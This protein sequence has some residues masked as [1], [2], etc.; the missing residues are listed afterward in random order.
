VVDAFARGAGGHDRLGCR[1]AEAYPRF[2]GLVVLRIE[3]AFDA[4]QEL[5]EPGLY[6]V[7]RD[8]EQVGQAGRP[9]VVKIKLSL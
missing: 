4:G 6:L 1:A 9:L 3:I 8:V 7:A 2:V 5:V